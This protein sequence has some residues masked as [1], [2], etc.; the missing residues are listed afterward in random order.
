MTQTAIQIGPRDNA[1]EMSLEEFESAEGRE[2]FLYEL[3]RG[4]IVVVDVPK[5]SHMGQVDS[6]RQQFAVYRAAKPSCI[7]RV[8]G[9]S[10]CK[11]LLTDLDS[12]RHPDIAVYKEP[13]P[14]DKQD[15]W[16]T[17]IPE[18]VIEVVSPGSEQR[19][20]VEKREEYMRFGIREYWIIDYG[21]KQ[22]LVLR[23][24]GGRWIDRVVQPGEA[25]STALLSGFEFSLSLV[26]DAAG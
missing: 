14:A 5:P 2:G 11:I 19:D 3:G 8:A 26:F 24:S 22:M 23:R 20:Y 13:P 1:R 16:S 7:Y 6:V 18:L 15:V 21:K 4:R 17:W 12:E 9:G 10:D 25:Y